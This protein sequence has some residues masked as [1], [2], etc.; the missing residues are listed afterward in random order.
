VT[1]LNQP[2][3]NRIAKP[4]NTA[5]HQR[6]SFWVRVTAEGGTVRWFGTRTLDIGCTTNSV[7]SIADNSFDTTAS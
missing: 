5:L 2:D 7:Y 6:Y 1:G 3:G 4:T